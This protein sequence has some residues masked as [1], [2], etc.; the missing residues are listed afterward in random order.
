MAKKKPRAIPETPEGK[1]LAE[2]ARAVG[3]PFELDYDNLVLTVQRWLARG[4]EANHELRR[5]V[6]ADRARLLAEM[7]LAHARRGLAIIAECPSC[8]ACAELAAETIERIDVHVPRLSERERDPTVAMPPAEG[9]P[10]ELLARLERIGGLLLGDLTAERKTPLYHIKVPHYARHAY[11]QVHISL[12]ALRYALPQWEALHAEIQARQL[13]PGPWPEI[14]PIALMLWAK[15]L[16]DGRSLGGSTLHHGT[17]LR[18]V[19][20][21]LGVIQRAV[22]ELELSGEEFAAAAQLGRGLER[23]L[24]GYVPGMEPALRAR[25]GTHLDRVWPPPA[26]RDEE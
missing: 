19:L 20:P 15:E 16:A 24:S 21:L 22:R 1:A 17:P 6:E 8:P 26:V 14:P 2:I 3:L 18:H 13:D 12:A 23:P 7:W 11:S 5:R 4:E 25:W 10:A 9:E